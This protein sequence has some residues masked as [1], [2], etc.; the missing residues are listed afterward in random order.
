MSSGASPSHGPPIISIGALVASYFLSPDF[1]YAAFAY[2]TLTLLYSYVFKHI[3]IVDVILL[4]AGFVLRAIAGVLVIREVKPGLPLTPWFVVCVL[5][6]SLFVAICKRRHELMY[7]E[8][9]ANHRKVLDEY[10]PAF[11]D[12]MIS[13]STSGTIISYALYLIAG[14]HGGV[15]VGAIPDLR[16]IS[17]LPFV[18]Y[19]VFRYLY[20]VYKRGEGGDP[21][22]LILKDKPFLANV[23][24]WLILMVSLMQ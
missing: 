2:Y 11:L 4:A 22:N 12:Q 23:V 3:A 17:T 9:A 18:I 20:L 10:S 21:E 6:L 19:G 1:F 14:P 7:V 24:V 16:M 15:S 13:V 8:D 5:F